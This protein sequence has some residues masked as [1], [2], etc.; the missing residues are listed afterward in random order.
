MSVTVAR[1]PSRQEISE[2][3]TQFRAWSDGR[4]WRVKN[5]WTGEVLAGDFPDEYAARAAANLAIADAVIGMFQG[6][7]A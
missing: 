6:A 1:V 3:V 2:T 7:R 4:S 5:M